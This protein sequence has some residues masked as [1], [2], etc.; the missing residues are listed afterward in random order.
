MSKIIVTGGKKLKGEIRIEGAK[1][2]VLP[3]LA[4]TILNGDENIIKNCPMFKDVEV[5]LD[6]LRRLGCKVKVEDNTAIIDSTTISS[7]IVPENLATEMRSSIILMGPLLA[8]EGKVTIS[9][10]GECVIV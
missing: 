4:A 7:T 10:P 8:R 3:I 6:I 1:N 2:S 5:I 9:Y